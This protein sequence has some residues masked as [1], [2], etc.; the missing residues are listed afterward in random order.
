MPERQTDLIP[1]VNIAYACHIYPGHVLY[2]VP[3]WIEYVSG[4]APVIMTEWGFVKGGGMPTDGTAS[5]YGRIF[6]A[7]I[8]SKPNV[9]WIAWCFDSV[10]GPSMFDLNWTL[11]GEGKS[12]AASRFRAQPEDTPENYMGRFAKDWLAERAR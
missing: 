12:T 10:Y 1:G 6:K 7:Y 4:V 3:G 5:G 2:S 8:D 11:L 9:G